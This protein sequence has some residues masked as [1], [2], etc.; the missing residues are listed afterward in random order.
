MNKHM[1]QFLTDLLKKI[2]MEQT[3]QRFQE[4]FLRISAISKL[5][6]LRNALKLFISHF[7]LTDK[8]KQVEIDVKL[9]NKC[10][11]AQKYLSINSND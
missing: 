9:K 4:I 10:E 5:S 7:I 1:L 11:L 6:Q 3:D 8:G 2:F